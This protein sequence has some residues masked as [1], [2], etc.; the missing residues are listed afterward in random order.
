M[1]KATVL[2]GA[3]FITL[4][5]LLYQEAEAQTVNLYKHV[6][7][8]AA[9]QDIPPEILNSRPKVLHQ[10]GDEKGVIISDG[11]IKDTIPSEEIKLDSD[12]WEKINIGDTVKVTPGETYI[13]EIDGVKEKYG[14]S[15]RYFPESP[16][17]GEPLHDFE[18]GRYD[19]GD[20]LGVMFKS[21]SGVN[22]EGTPYRRI[23][24]FDT[25]GLTIEEEFG[26]ATDPGSDRSLGHIV[27]EL[28][29]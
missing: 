14:I 8:Q 3:M 5:S 16:Y 7:S 11:S 13:L 18:L 9:Y 26:G 21:I 19:G 29:K 24:F 22:P 25:Y 1:K 2:T 23:E 15:L 12:N 4:L 17:V 20:N 6:G 27:L 28:S 10:I